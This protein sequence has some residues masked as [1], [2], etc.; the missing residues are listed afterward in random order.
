[1][2]AACWHSTSTPLHSASPLGLH[3]WRIGGCCSSDAC[4]STTQP[5]CAKALTA[6]GGMR[7][8]ERAGAANG[9]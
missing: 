4:R 6:L 8:A 3:I 1:M 7:R 9:R 2:W 5:S